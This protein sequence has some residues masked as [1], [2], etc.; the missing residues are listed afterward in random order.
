[1]N[2]VNIEYLVMNYN[3][4]L[5]DKKL[6]I[7]F[8]D[9]EAKNYLKPNEENMVEFNRIYHFIKS[10][11]WRRL[12]RTKSGGISVDRKK[13]LGRGWDVEWNH[14]SVDLILVNGRYY[15]RFIF[16]QP[17]GRDE[18]IPI[19]G[20][21]AFREF[22]RELAKDG[23][24]LDWF[25]IDNGKDVKKDIESPFIGLAADSVKNRI[26]NNAH[27]ID[28]HSSH[29]AGMAKYY[30][31]LRPTIERIYWEKQSIE[32]HDSWDYKV[33][34]AILNA[35]WGMLQSQYK[36]YKWAHIARDG[37][38]DTNDR[39][40][41]LAM[42]LT[43]EGRTIIAYNTDGIW[44]CGDVYHGEGEGDGLG[45][46]SNDH[47]NC[48]IRFKSA[49]CYEFE[50]AGKYRAVVRG[51]TSLDQLKPREEWKWG[52]IYHSAPFQ[53]RFDEER[54][55]YMTYDDDTAGI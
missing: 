16:K 7:N 49:G 44:Y 53:Y 3:Y 23:I 32:D 34:K 31:E 37:I 1:M 55:V 11:G 21:I 46:W 39:I 2:E 14:Y 35:T 30:P 41:E 36:G 40:R 47:T 43:E 15:W 9:K 51:Y 28:F 24:D 33:K 12:V 18:E 17:T 26:Y 29:P 13:F 54:G 6:D 25:A 5:Y 50:E 22:V 8:L 10:L 48:R 4:A 27:H 19:S 20:T 42:R 38:K 45:E 52:D